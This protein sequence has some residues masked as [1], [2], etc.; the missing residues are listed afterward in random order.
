MN[1]SKSGNVTLTLQAD[2]VKDALPHKLDPLLGGEIEPRGE[3]VIL[4]DRHDRDRPR[5]TL[6]I[7]NHGDIARCSTATLHVLLAFLVASGLTL[8]AARRSERK[9]RGE[10]AKLEVA[11]RRTISA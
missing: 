1:S 3:V 2:A 5:S 6:T 7:P 8:V 11:H 9:R 4:I 10:G